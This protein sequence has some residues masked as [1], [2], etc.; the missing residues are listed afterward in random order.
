MVSLEQFIGAYPAFT[1][2]PSALVQAALDSAAADTS[3]DIW[4]DA[5]AEGLMLKAA[6][7]LALTPE[8]RA[9][10]LS[11]DEGL[12]IYHKRLLR[13]RRLVAVGAHRVAGG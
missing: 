9:L 12:S 5:Y 6:D 13:M 1:D 10:R 11:S 8:G 3:E 4:G 2:A 7:I